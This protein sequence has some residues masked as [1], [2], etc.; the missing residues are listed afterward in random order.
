M[1]GVPIAEAR[2]LRAQVMETI[3]GTDFSR[4]DAAPVQSNA[5]ALSEAQSGFS[6]N[7]LAT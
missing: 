5:Q 6:E 7:F 4:L 2:A 3:T 1:H